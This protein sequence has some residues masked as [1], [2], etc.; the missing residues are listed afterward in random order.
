MKVGSHATGICELRQVRKEA[1]VSEPFCVPWGCLAGADSTGCRLE[2]LVDSGCTVTLCNL[3]APERMTYISL[4]RKWRPQSFSELVG[5][6]H[7]S[8]TLA[9]AVKDDRVAHAYLFAGPRGTGKTSTAKIL[10][11]SVNCVEGPTTEPCGKCESCLA[12]AIGNSLDVIEMDAA[13]NRGIEDIR[14]LR[15]K[16]AFAATMARRKVYIIDEVHMLTEP[17]FNALLKT[18]EEP[19]EHVIFV[20]ATTDP[21]KVP[22]TITSRCQQFEFRRIPRPALI[23]HLEKIAKAEKIKISK[24]ALAVVARHAEGSL[25]DAIGMLDQL[26]AYKDQKISEDEVATFLGL[27]SSA[28]V[29]EAIE[30]IIAQDS[31]A[32]F[33]FVDTLT[34]AGRDLRQF[35][36]ATLGYARD[37]FI[38]IHVSGAESRRQLIHRGDETIEQMIGQAE[39]LG[40]TKV[41]SILT[42]TSR[43]FDE[44]RFAA[45]PRLALELALIGLMR[46]EEMTLEALAERVSRLEEGGVRTARPDSGQAVK[47]SKQKQRTTKVPAIGKLAPQ[48]QDSAL[49]APSRSRSLTA[50]ADLDISEIELAWPEVLAATRKKK[51]SLGAFLVECRPS[52]IEEG[53]LVLAFPPKSDFAQQEL[54]KASNKALLKEALSEV[55]GVGLDFTTSTSAGARVEG[56]KAKTPPPAKEPKVEAKPAV[57]KEESKSGG[58]GE[59]EE[60][61]GEDDMIDLL[62][63]SFGAEIVD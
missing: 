13:S 39:R 45:E 17:A 27:P 44:L 6:N 49:A 29:E 2:S 14:D 43:L 48:D 54:T 34:D 50:G 26:S 10:A 31:A 32:I 38:V 55:L 41:R 36:A 53:R 40:A 23:A 18:I 16:V 51:L 20:L 30:L 21:Q 42:E 8:Q 7:V 60:P 9:N 58:N 19:P 52:V 35:V 24:E 28:Q 57:E 25:R 4:Y 11:K 1:A 33:E 5:Q 62:K 56:P 22:A 46:G 61:V 59:P 15:D 3:Q 12:T 63:E 47:A 37:L